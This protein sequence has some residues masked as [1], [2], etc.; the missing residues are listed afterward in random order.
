MKEIK[1]ERTF[2]TKISYKSMIANKTL[3]SF[4]T[5]EDELDKEVDSND[6]DGN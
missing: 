2:K 6:E 5:Q 1:T 3:N 4:E